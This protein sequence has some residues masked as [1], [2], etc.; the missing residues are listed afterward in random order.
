MSIKADDVHMC[1]TTRVD[2]RAEA[3]R[4]LINVIQPNP[5]WQPLFVTD[6]ATLDCIT[7]LDPAL[8]R[9]RLEFYF[10]IPLPVPVSAR[11]WE[12]VDAMKVIM[13]TWPESEPAVH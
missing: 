2:L 5:V 11:L 7:D 12:L 6:E 13:P 8:V 9:A 1:D 3:I 10:G 4:I